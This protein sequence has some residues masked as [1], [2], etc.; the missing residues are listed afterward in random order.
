MPSTTMSATSRKPT[1]KLTFPYP[2]LSPI[3]GTPS[4]SSLQALQKQIYTN[5]HAINSPCGGDVNSYLALVMTAS[6]YLLCAPVWPSH[7]LFILVTPPSMP[8][9]PLAQSTTKTTS[10]SNATIS[11]SR[12]LLKS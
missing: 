3:V 11:S 8:T 9:V 2:V 7:Y 1:S 4:N 10:T 6:A 12:L 5:A